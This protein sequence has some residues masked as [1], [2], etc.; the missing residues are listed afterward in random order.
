MTC[1]ALSVVT[2]VSCV[3]PTLSFVVT[4][5]MQ[6]IVVCVVTVVVCSGTVDGVA[7]VLALVSHS[8]PQEI[9]SAQI[10]AVTIKREII[11]LN[12]MLPPVRVF[13]GSA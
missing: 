11:F 5:V 8:S 13:L 10:S 12:I 7:K 6:L 4:P 2:N 9:R 3:V 1:V